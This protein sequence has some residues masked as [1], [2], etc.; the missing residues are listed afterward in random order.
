MRKEIEIY[1]LYNFEN[2][3]MRN[4]LDWSIWDPTD[5]YRLDYD[6]NYPE[7]FR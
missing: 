6:G 4:D 2:A 3:H 7:V 5:G 1:D